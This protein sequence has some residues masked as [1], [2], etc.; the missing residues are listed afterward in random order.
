MLRSNFC[1]ADI[2]VQVCHQYS[3]LSN[4]CRDYV[5]DAAP[6]ME[7]EIT[8]QVMCRER[9]RAEIPGSPEPYLES[10]AVYRMFCERAVHRRVLLFHSSAIAVDGQAY[11]FAAPSGT[12][13]STHTALWRRMLGDRVQVVNDDKPLLRV[14]ENGVL[15]YGTPWDGKHHLSNRICVPVGGICFLSRGEQNTIHR[16][17]PNEALPSLLEQT[18][19]P[20][21]AQGTAQMLNLL[22]ELCMRVP[23]WSLA[24]NISEEAAQLSYHTMRGDVKL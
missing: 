12:G 18:F 23:L 24:C 22:I 19:R 8:E 15:A 4:Q 6:E 20:E 17:S 14:T 21:D 1:F 7:I 10:L 9:E 16:V 3:Y 2:P 5:C 11:L 13:K